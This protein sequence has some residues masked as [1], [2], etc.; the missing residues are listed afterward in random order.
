M[1]EQLLE[2][3]VGVGR[4][5][6]DEE[7]GQIQEGVEDVQRQVVARQP[8]QQVA[9]HQEAAVL[10]HLLL[11]RRRALDQLAQERHQFAAHRIVVADARRRRRR[12]RRRRRRPCCRRRLDGQVELFQ[13]ERGETISKI[14]PISVLSSST[15][16]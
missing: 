11:H 7:L 16:K 4:R 1:V 12:L 5:R 6:R 2:E 10:H 8:L 9:D 14:D 15:V 13:R 3:D